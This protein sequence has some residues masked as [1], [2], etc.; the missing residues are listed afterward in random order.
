MNISSFIFFLFVFASLICY[1]LLPKKLSYISLLCFSLFFLFY[2]SLSV[3]N[4]VSVSS[5]FLISY[6]SGLLIDKFKDKSKSIC[7]IGVILILLIL[8]YLKYANF[9]ITLVNNI[10]RLNFNLLNNESPLGVSYFSLIMIGYIVDIYWC[11]NGAEKNPLKVL[12]FMIYYPILTSGPF[13]KYSEIKDNLFTKNSFKFD[14]I[15]NGFLRVLWGLFKVLIISTRISIFVTFVYS[16]LGSMNGLY[17]IL[18]ILAYTFELYTN[19]SGSIDIVI[20]VS[21]MF[22]I[23]LPENFDNPFA[24]ETITEFWRVWHITLGNWLRNYIFYP[25]LKSD[26]IQNLNKVCKD[27][28]G[29]KGKKIPTFLC[30]FVLWFLIGFWHGGSFKFILA[31]GILQ[32]IFIMVED[33]FGLV[34]KT[35]KKYI[36]VLRVIRTFI[37]FSL[38]M[39]FF[40]AASVSEGIE[41]FK[42]LFNTSSLNLIKDLGLSIFDVVVIIIS[43]VAL[44]IFDNKKEKIKEY[45]GNKSFE[46]RIAIALAAVL[47]ILLFGVYGFGFNASEFIYG[48]F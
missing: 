1:Y 13:I 15:I 41:V 46:F 19:F 10:F 4:I 27:K 29:K 25:L 33:L 22:G 24:S 5:I 30:M 32:F 7:V 37:L 8:G 47:T 2:N 14:N 48:N 6:V 23:S 28:F 44:L 9:F 17:I 26:M 18:A 34:N 3:L 38:S 36:R 21:H 42:N 20:G 35:D 16:N 43:L 11:T 31:S 40:R 39:V 45:I 12:L